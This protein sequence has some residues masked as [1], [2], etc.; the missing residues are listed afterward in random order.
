[1]LPPAAGQAAVENCHREWS[2]PT[3]QDLP[4]NEAARLSI[5]LS[6]SVEETR[7]LVDPASRMTAAL[8]RAG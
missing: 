4:S 1:M 3:W 7:Y 2:S 5:D 8:K 6:F